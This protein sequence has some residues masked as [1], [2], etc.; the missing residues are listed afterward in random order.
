M[1]RHCPVTQLEAFEAI[2][3]TAAPISSGFPHLLSGMGIYFFNSFSLS[4]EC[5]FIESLKFS[6]GIG[7]GAIAF[8]LILG[9]N[10]RANVAVKLFTAALEAA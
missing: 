10:S 1:K 5:I 3:T 9:A 7:P 2:K 8:T 6:V 4:S